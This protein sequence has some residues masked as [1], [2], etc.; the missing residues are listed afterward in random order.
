M[1][2]HDFIYHRERERNAVSNLHHAMTVRHRLILQTFQHE[3]G[4]PEKRGNVADGALCTC[5]TGREYPVLGDRT[6]ALSVDLKM[7]GLF[8]Q[9]C[10]HVNE[11]DR[12]KSAGA[13]MAGKSPMGSD[14]QQGPFSKA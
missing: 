4:A 2:P 9:A 13:G 10:S 14:G 12:K 1:R 8:P 6:A 11:G 5:K 7:P 3:K